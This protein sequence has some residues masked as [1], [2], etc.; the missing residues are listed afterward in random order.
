MKTVVL[1]AVAIVCALTA[2]AAEFDHTF[3]KLNRVL[4]QRVQDGQVD[5]AA[6]LADPKDLNSAL[7]EM[8]AVKKPEFASWSQWQQISFLINIYN[9]STLRLIVDHYPLKSI[10]SIGNILRGPFKQPVVRL[11]GKTTTLDYVEHEMLRRNYREP[12]V[13][14]VLVCGARSCPPLRNEVYTAER[15]NAQLDDQGR[16]FMSARAKNRFDSAAGILHLSP[17]FKWFREDFEEKSGSVV[18]FVAPFFPAET[19]AKIEAAPKIQIRYTDYNW[20]L[21]ATRLP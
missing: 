13:H 2:Q 14:F 5:Y 4:S 16:I 9:A 20:S 7:D 10:K 21:N 17:I 19:R 8:A 11:F 3:A 15:L 12:R 6:L 18:K 1:L